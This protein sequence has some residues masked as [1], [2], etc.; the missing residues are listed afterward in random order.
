VIIPPPEMGHPLEVSAQK[1]KE[2]IHSIK[3][4]IGMFKF[5]WLYFICDLKCFIVFIYQKYCL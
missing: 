2:S 1:K 5:S 3:N 4:A